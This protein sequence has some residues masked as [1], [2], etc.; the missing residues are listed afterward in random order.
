MKDETKVGKRI[1][2]AK[3]CVSE[4]DALEKKNY[5]PWKPVLGLNRKNRKSQKSKNQ[6]KQEQ[7][8]AFIGKLA[9][10]V[11]ASV[12]IHLHAPYPIESLLGTGVQL[13]LIAKGF[14]QDHL[15]THPQAAENVHLRSASKI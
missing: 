3:N 13:L 4:R 6:K 15:S 12:G 14:L 5:F 9:Y 10:C 1:E 11:S 7:I 8:M 2:P